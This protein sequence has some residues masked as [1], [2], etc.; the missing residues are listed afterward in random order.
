M[1]RRGK[2]ATAIAVA[3]F[4]SFIR[5]KISGSPNRAGTAS[6]KLMDPMGKVVWTASGKA[7]VAPL[8]S[9]ILR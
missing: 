2:T 9:N 8:S 4:N 3:S 6:I 7:S 5:R 1:Q